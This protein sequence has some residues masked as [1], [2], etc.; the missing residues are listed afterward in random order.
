ML[1]NS[2]KHGVNVFQGIRV[3]EIQ[4]DGDQP[5]SAT[6]SKLTTKD[7]GTIS[8]DYLVDAS[9]RAR[10]MANRYLKSINYLE[11]FQNV[12]IW[13]YWKNTKI[14]TTDLQG[15]LT[16]G[17]IQYGWLWGIPLKDETMSIGLVIHKDRFT[18]LKKDHSLEEIYLRGIRESDIFTTMTEKSE[19]VTS[20]KVEKDYSYLSTKLTGPGYFL[21]GDSGCFIDP[22][23]SSGVHLAMH[24]ALLA[25]ASIASVLAGDIDELAARDFYQRSYQSHF[26]RWALLV[27]GF[28]EV[29]KSKE[30]CFWRAQQLSSNEVA[31][32]NISSLDMKQV[33]ATLVSGLIDFEE[34][35]DSAVL[36][37][38]TGRIENYYDK[39]NKDHTLNIQDKLNSSNKKIFQYLNRVQKRDPIAAK[40]R[41]QAGGN[42]TFM[43]GLD[44]ENAVNELYVS[45]SPFIRLAKT[46]TV[47]A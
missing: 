12:A 25:A 19:L 24:S 30:D 34:L 39:G 21:V 13:G 42:E 46:E 23:L 7:S 43:V 17:S 6:W 1:N 40:Q 47:E 2:E 31:S 41:Y 9:G 45:T 14:P 29:N 37:D 35:S 8:F 5:K 44:E 10:I 11:A 33:F 20:V 36:E 26:F 38:A 3:D 27:S 15:P 16:V 4:F 28:Y 32:L 18:E 22:L